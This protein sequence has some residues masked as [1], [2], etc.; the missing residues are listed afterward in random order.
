[1]GIKDAEAM[2][3]AGLAGGVLFDVAQ[4]VRQGDGGI[5]GLS[6]GADA[7]TVGFAL[8]SAAVV[9]HPG[10]AHGINRGVDQGAQILTHHTADHVARQG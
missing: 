6:G 9:A 2:L 7:D 3:Q 5:T 10:A 8:L 4:D 1:M